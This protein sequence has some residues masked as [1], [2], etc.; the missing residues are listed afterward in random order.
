MS[1]SYEQTLNSRHHVYGHDSLIAVADGM[2]P[3]VDPPESG[4]KVVKTT[5]DGVSFAGQI[6]VSGTLHVQWL[7]TTANPADSTAFLAASIELDKA[8][9]ERLPYFGGD[10]APEVRVDNPEAAVRVAF[11]KTLA[12]LILDKSKKI[13]ELHGS[14]LLSDLSIGECGSPWASGTV[15][16]A[17]GQK[18]LGSAQPWDFGDC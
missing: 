8:E 4:L 5:D 2:P 14:F 13:A 11:D 9:L 17:S 3:L 18:Y 1:P 12:A 16:S 7:E 6:R 15:V 10:K